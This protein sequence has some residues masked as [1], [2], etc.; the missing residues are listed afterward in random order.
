MTP[1]GKSNRI[2][3]SYLRDNHAAIGRFKQDVRHER[4]RAPQLY[5]RPHPQIAR[6]QRLDTAKAST[7]G[8]VFDK[9]TFLIVTHAFSSTRQIAVVP[10]PT[11]KMPGSWAAETGQ[12]APTPAGVRHPPGS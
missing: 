10:P 3:L 6:G 8:N 7:L 12:T 4:Y 1:I 9:G 11:G 2:K 5:R